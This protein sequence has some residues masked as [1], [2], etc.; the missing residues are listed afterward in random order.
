MGVAVAKDESIPPPNVVKRP[1]LE[2]K[3]QYSM[4]RDLLGAGNLAV[5]GLG[6]PAGKE[7]S[8]YCG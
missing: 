5:E 2:V 4:K 1:S 3:K 6:G 8:L 7:A